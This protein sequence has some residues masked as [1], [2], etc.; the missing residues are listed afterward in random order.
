MIW[1]YVVAFVILV[2]ATFLLRGRRPDSGM[3]SYRKHIDA[4]SS[5]SRRG[6]R[7]VNDRTQSTKRR[8]P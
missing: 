6:V 8:K 2:V 3:T 5:E 7:E 1:V 4:L